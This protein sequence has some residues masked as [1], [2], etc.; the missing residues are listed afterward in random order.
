MQQFFTKRFLLTINHEKLKL[1]HQAIDNKTLSLRYNLK[2]L[3]N[4]WQS[5]PA[6]SNYVE[7]QKTNLKSLSSFSVHN[8]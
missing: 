7:I 8:W 1:N 4:A 6:I 5:L 2:E 3:R